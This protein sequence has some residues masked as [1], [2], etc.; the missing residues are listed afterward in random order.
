M[1][2]LVV[3]VEAIHSSSVGA[4]AHKVGN[5]PPGLSARKGT[6]VI[7]SLA[8]A[9]SLA[10]LAWCEAS[11]SYTNNNNWRSAIAQNYSHKEQ[12]AVTPPKR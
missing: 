2:P 6:P 3:N 7:P 12:T 4:S 1:E 11:T 9:Y 5:I 10:L 8:R